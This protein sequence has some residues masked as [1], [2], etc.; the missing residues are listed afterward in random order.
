MEQDKDTFAKR[1]A[2]WLKRTVRWPDKPLQRADYE[3]GLLVLARAFTVGVAYVSASPIPGLT[4]SFVAIFTSLLPFDMIVASARPPISVDEWN[5][6]VAMVRPRI[7]ATAITLLKGVAIGAIMGI[8]VVLGLSH[9]LGAVFTAGLSYIWALSTRHN[10]STYVALLSGLAL[11]DRLAHLDAVETV[12]VLQEIA[13]AILS[14][15]GGTFM[16]L[17]AGWIVGLL[18]GSVTRVVL[19]KPYRS[20]RSSAYDLPMEMRPFNEVLHIGENS[21]ILTGTVEADASLA[22]LSLA[23]S[24]LRQRFGA[25]VLA[26]NRNGDEIVMP[27]G[28]LVLAVGD[29]LTLLTPREHSPDV[30]AQL[31]G[32][33]RDGA[34][35][36]SERAGETASAAEGSRGDDPTGSAAEKSGP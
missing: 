16:A 23:E 35:R 28:D 9:Q 8:G 13:T 25:T 6:L 21:F 11:F 2:Q 24:R 18:T 19:S 14:S 1:T 27:K 20:L 26:V 22:G 31:H 36:P 12:R 34:A 17:I 33:D 5:G 30:Y 29:E 4:S 15:G 3:P 10:I 32:P 7:V